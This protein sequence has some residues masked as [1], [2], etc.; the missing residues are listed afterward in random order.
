MP[1][2]DVQETWNIKQNVFYFVQE[3]CTTVQETCTR[4]I[5]LQVAMT[6]MQVFGTCVTGIEFET[7]P[8]PNLI[9]KLV[10]CFACDVA[11]LQE[12][13]MC[14]NLTLKEV[15][16]SSRLKTAVNWSSY[17]IILLCI[18]TSVIS[19]VLHLHYNNDN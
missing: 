8:N 3:T 15:S 7:D 14:Y 12:R 17:I 4:K 11:K 5:L 2:T 18:C 10:N 16:T 13:R 19:T 6:D 1:V 9:P